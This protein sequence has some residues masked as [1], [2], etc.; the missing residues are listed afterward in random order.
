MI[1]HE[2]YVDGFGVWDNLRLEGFTPGLNVIY[3][4]NEAGNRQSRNRR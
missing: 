2:V 1:I 3:G 4:P